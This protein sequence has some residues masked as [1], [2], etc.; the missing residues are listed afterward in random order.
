MPVTRRELYNDAVRKLKNYIP[1]VS[2][3]DFIS[4]ILSGGADAAALSLDEAAPQA[5]AAQKF[6]D[7]ANSFVDII[8]GGTYTVDAIGQMN[9]F[10]NPSGGVPP[11]ILG[12]IRRFI[13]ITLP[14]VLLKGE[15][16]CA[17][18]GLISGARSFGSVN[19]GNV[20]GV[21]TLRPKKYDP[22]GTT[23]FYTLEMAGFKN[24]DSNPANK[25][26]RATKSNPHV[27]VIE[28]LDPR[29]GPAIR[30][31]AG[32]SIFTSMIPTHVAS[33]AV[34]Y[35]SVSVISSGSSPSQGGLPTVGNF[36]MVRYLR[37]KVTTDFQQDIYRPLISLGDGSVKPGGMELF[38]APQTMVSD[39]S[40]IL[41]PDL[42]ST[43]P[44]D[45]FRPLMTLNSLSID[46]VPA[47]AGMM[48]YK[49]ASMNV[50]LH[51]RGRLEEIAPLVQPGAYKDTEIEI[52]YGW[53]IDPRSQNATSNADG[54]LTGF[55][56]Q[57]DVFAQLIDSLRCRERFGVVNST[58][59]FDDSGQVSIALTL[60][61]KSAYEM[62]SIDISSTESK[63][64][65]QRLKST[66]EDIKGIVST[67]PGVANFLS[68]A[69]IDAASSAEGAIS[70]DPTKLA[71]LKAE[72]DKLMGKPRKAGSLGEV[73][74]K[75]GEL[76]NT[77]GN[78]QD[79]G[80]KGVDKILAVL[81]DGDEIFP[82]TAEITA[83]GNS[84]N[85]HGDF[86]KGS[87]SLGR[88]VLHLVAK[89]LA[90]TNKF[91]EIQLIFGKVN[92]RAGNVRNLSMAAFPLDAEKLE[93]TLK[94]LYKENL[95]VSVSM[96]LGTLGAEHV[97]NVGYP[98]YGFAAK[99]SDGN[100]TGTQGDID[101]ILKSAGINDANFTLPK[102]YLHA[103]CVPANPSSKTGKPGGTILRLFIGD[104]QCSPYQ[105]YAE[106]VNAARTD[107]SFLLDTQGLDKV[108]NSSFKDVWWA[109]LDPNAKDSRDVAFE[110]LK[111]RPDVL[112]PAAAT[113]GQTA[114][115]KS[116]DLSK[117]F[118][119]GNSQSIKRF[120]SEG[121]PVVRYG[122]GAGML[123]NIAVS[124]ISDP[125]LA[126]I[127]IIAADE[128]SGEGA[129]ATKKKGLPMIV[130]PTEVTVDMLGC[131][132]MNFGQ[133][134]YIDF[135]TGTTIDNIYACT[136]VSHTFSPGEFSTSAKF[137]INV[138][139][140]GIYN[141]NKRQLDILAAQTQQA[142]GKSA[143]SIT[144]LK[145]AK[146]AVGWVE[147]SPVTLTTLKRPA[148]SDGA[149]FIRIWRQGNAPAE[150]LIAN[151][152]K[153]IIEN[154]NHEI[155]TTDSRSA[156]EI[157]TTLNNG[158]LQC[159]EIP[160]LSKKIKTVKGFI[161]S[162]AE[163]TVNKQ[164]ITV[165]LKTLQ[166]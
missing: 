155:V 163:N 33:R 84:K 25:E 124:S 162:L 128:A 136:S 2:N 99:Y 35:V 141:S 68:E 52:E 122:N 18:Y 106:L 149:V 44:V 165:D 50:T 79:E 20:V 31:T 77:V 14:S 22:K 9:D 15:D 92:S 131:P 100:L 47:G 23:G 1:A 67:S 87:Y 73:L 139:A 62:R 65:A 80:A 34:P 60:F 91:D 129:T 143:V 51:D 78:F 66:I 103:E 41:N 81:N 120:I 117:L 83:T 74:T 48:S 82:C 115:Y 45:R 71:E 111:E 75:L 7:I 54:K 95:N 145:P 142:N 96:L 125:A 114:T 108:K 150:G 140:Y 40:D 32:L 133:S 61:T 27:T 137:V 112:I 64:V 153:Y 132:L 144:T 105:G 29:I 6:S 157:L 39:L 19:N 123:K 161:Y 36:N 4:S 151:F 113:A 30:D 130:T 10:L 126:T 88:V 154:E 86:K 102:L 69:M 12:P 116:I 90:K 164:P 46:V 135:G 5:V 134:V 56:L 110:K 43:R 42:F 24:D 21:D 3:S 127:N 159:Y 119:T 72:V 13:R 166:V 76:T 59:N 26:L 53:S 146:K 147:I 98:A 70:L 93:A 101:A 97:S 28:L 57:D 148:Y 118:K 55:A 89:V 49:N 94:K 37:G 38:T 85:K 152:E 158:D 109:D 107:S 160:Y 17:K 121:L 11:D 138:G 104:E 156:P 63:G 16:N 58:F 8:N